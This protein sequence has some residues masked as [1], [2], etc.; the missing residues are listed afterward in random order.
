[1]TFWPRSVMLLRRASEAARS[2]GDAL[3][4]EQSHLNPHF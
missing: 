1:M 3:Q 2:S 4:S